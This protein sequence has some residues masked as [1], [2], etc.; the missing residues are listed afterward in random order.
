[1]KAALLL[2]TL[3]LLFSCNADKKQ[4]DQQAENINDTSIVN[5]DTATMYRRKRFGPSNWKEGARY[6]DSVEKAGQKQQDTV[7]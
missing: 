7:N 2:L 5:S 1:M 4:I 3:V 6:L